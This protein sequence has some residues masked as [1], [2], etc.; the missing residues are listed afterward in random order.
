MDRMGDSIIGQGQIPMQKWTE[1]EI[2]QKG[3]IQ[4]QIPMQKCSAG[5]I[6]YGIKD[7]LH[8]RKGQKGT[9]HYRTGYRTDFT[10]KWTE[11]EISLHVRT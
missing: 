1:G 4:G 2:P 7:R 10:A 5:E 9:F 6:H 8:C 11:G 3:R